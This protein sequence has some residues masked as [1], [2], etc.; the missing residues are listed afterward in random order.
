[1]IPPEV[2]QQA[3]NLEFESSDLN[4]TLTVEA[5]LRRLLTTLLEEEESFSGKRPFGNSGWKSEVEAVFIKADLIAG[6]LDS[7]GYVDDSDSVAADAILTAI[8][9]NLHV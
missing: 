7:Q 3:A 9:N 2:I 8:A 4:E 1:M 5:W 6:K